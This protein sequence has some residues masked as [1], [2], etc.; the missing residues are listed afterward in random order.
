MYWRPNA[1]QRGFAFPAASL[2]GPDRCARAARLSRAETA[3]PVYPFGVKDLAGAE[4]VPREPAGRIT[5][6]AGEPDI[7]LD[8][9]L[10]PMVLASDAVVRDGE[11][12]GDPTEGALVV[13]AAKGG[14]DAVS[15]RERYPRIAELPFDAAYK[16]MAT[17]H[18]MTDASGQ[19]VIR[20]YVKGAPD[21]LLARAATLLDADSGPA[22]ADERAREWYQAENQR[23]GEQGL[24]VIATARKDLDPAAFDPHADLLSLMTGLELLA[25]VGIVDPPRPTAKASI[26]TAKKAGIRVRMITGDYGVTGAAVARQLGIDGTVIT[27][28]EFGAMTDEEAL[29][30]IDDVGVIARVSPRHKVRLVEVLRKQGQIVAMTGDGV[31]DAPAVKKADIGISMGTGTEV[32]KEA[33]VM[34]LTDDN[35]STIVKAVEL[36]RGLYDNLTKYIWYQI[37]GLF[38]Y[39]ITFLGASIFNI[40]GGIPLLPLQTLW[41]S[42]TTLSLQSV[43]LGYSKPAAG[44]MERPPRPPSRPIL[45]RGLTVWLAF[46]GLVTAVGTL[47]V[48]SWADKAHGLAEA[49]TMGMVTLALFF[50]FFSIESKEERESAFSPATFSDKTFVRTTG[51]SFLLL[52]LSTVLSIFH[53]V[54]KTTTLDVLQW[55]ICTAVAL[56][57]VVAVEI[58]KAVLR[59]AA[60]RPLWRSGSPAPGALSRLRALGRAAS[61]RSPRSGLDIIVHHS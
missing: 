49:R 38:G 8:E 48:I 18:K 29:A 51:L 34:I 57:V 59:R 17:F 60:A 32:T 44:L 37:G 45:T 23:L 19:E 31:N 39:I 4:R 36:G 42:F 25:I 3:P 46:V 9:F 6:V 41:V 22:P 27:G 30:R 54:M 50:L 21:Q 12:I 24:R 40:A 43:G 2:L 10:M 20:C 56:S 26:A 14:I 1:C 55:L 7:P 28:A 13:L 16:L 47:S 52:L 35:F 53:T 15:T 58:R 11:L 5:R 33:A 61:C